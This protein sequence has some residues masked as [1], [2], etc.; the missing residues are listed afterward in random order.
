MTKDNLRNTAKLFSTKHS[1]FHKWA[2]RIIF[3]LTEDEI[4]GDNYYRI[5]DD[6]DEDYEKYDDIS[7]L[8]NCQSFEELEDLLSD[9]YTEI[10]SK[11]Y[12]SQ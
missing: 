7:E 4:P 10:T 5:D 9:W 6:I 3:E 11:S 2:S 8:Y 1:E 12:T